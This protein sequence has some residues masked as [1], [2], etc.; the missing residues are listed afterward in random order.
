M[1]GFQ[2]ILP[3]EAKRLDASLM[4]R[5]PSGLPKRIRQPNRL[6]EMNRT[7]RIITIFWPKRIGFQCAALKTV[8]NCWIS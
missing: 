8:K 2:Y 4:G 6:P 5:R 7:G 3:I 1:P